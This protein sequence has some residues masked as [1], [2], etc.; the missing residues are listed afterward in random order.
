MEALER[1]EFSLGEIFKIKSFT[2]SET[3][4][5]KGGGKGCDGISCNFAG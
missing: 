2:T 3:E 1:Y 4:I 5:K